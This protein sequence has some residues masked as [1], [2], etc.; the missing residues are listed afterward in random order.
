MQKN[1]RRATKEGESVLEKME[2]TA[3]RKPSNPREKQSTC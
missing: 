1:Y 3:L 2:Q